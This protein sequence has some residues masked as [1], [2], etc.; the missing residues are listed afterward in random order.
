M[1]ILG[2]RC[3]GKERAEGYFLGKARLTGSYMEALYRT[4]IPTNEIK[5]NLYVKEV[6]NINMGEEEIRY[7]KH[8][9]NYPETKLE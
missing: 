8:F 9:N 4:N 1:G 5:G 2:W 7:F 3:W 6:K